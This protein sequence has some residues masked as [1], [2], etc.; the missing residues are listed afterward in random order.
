MV[1]FTQKISNKVI[2]IT[3][4]KAYDRGSPEQINCTGTKNKQHLKNSTIKQAL[5]AGACFL[6]RSEPANIRKKPTIMIGRAFSL[7][8]LPG[9]APGSAR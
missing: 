2:D 3:A 5:L 7:V 9:I 8:E 1:F 6:Y 4:L